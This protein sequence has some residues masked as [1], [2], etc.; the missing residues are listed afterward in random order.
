MRLADGH[1]P[2]G[3]E[4]RRTDH[5]YRCPNGECTGRVTIDADTTERL[6]VA[7]VGRLL[8]NL[9]GEAS[10]D[11]DVAGAEAALETAER[12]L[13]A[14]VRAFSALG[15]VAAQDRLEEL[16]LERDKAAD[17]L[18]ELRGRTAA[19]VTVTAADLDTAPPEILRDLIAATL[20]SV[21]VAPGRIAA[22]RLA[23]VAR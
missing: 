15:D 20:E 21:T 14:A 3:P 17:L 11:A 5:R 9:H 2:E 1:P 7:E 23:F 4:G 19:V 13:T 12:E 22:N 10:S 16:K 8:D 6:V 18:H